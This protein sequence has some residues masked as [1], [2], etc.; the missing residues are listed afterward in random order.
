MNNEVPFAI[1]GDD[2]FP[3]LWRN[4]RAMNEQ[5]ASRSLQIASDSEHATLHWFNDYHVALAGEFVRARERGAKI[6]LF[7]HTAFPSSEVFLTLPTRAE[8]IRALLASDVLGFQ[9]FDA[10]HFLTAVRQLTGIRPVYRLG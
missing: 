7:L 2:R 6:G 3:V 8:L 10:R 5:F 9:M 1:S 4:F